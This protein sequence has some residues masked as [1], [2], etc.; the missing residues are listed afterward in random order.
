[1]KYPLPFLQYWYE[2]FPLSQQETTPTGT[3]M[4]A[5]SSVLVDPDMTV[6]SISGDTQFPH[7]PP[8]KPV[9]LKHWTLVSDDLI[10]VVRKSGQ[11]KTTFKCN[12]VDGTGKTCGTERNILYH[13]GKAVSTTNLIRHVVDMT[14]KDSSHNSVDTVLKNASPNYCTVDGERRKMHTFTESFTHH[15]D[16]LWTHGGGLSWNMTHTNKDFQQYIRGFEPHTRFPNHVCARKT[17]LSFIKITQSL[18]F[19]LRLANLTDS[20]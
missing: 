4:V 1:M 15:V 7:L 8:N 6:E 12:I 13:R 16:F 10:T 9:V 2:T 11:Y 5:P 3:S 14:H 19:K 20:Q 17:S 18:I